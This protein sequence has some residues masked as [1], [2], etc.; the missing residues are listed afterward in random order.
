MQNMNKK[1]NGKR[2]VVA[3]PEALHYRLRKTALRER[4]KLNELVKR[5]L[6]NGLK[7]YSWG[8]DH[9]EP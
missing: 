4:T 5:Y 9:L 6:W 7:T 3:I 1:S 8:P 2:Y